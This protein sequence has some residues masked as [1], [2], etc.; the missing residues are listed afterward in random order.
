[1][2]GL[3]A[4][5]LQA[6]LYRRL[7]EDAALGDLVGAAIYD[8]PLER[9]PVAHQNRSTS[10]GVSRTRNAQPWLKPALG[11]RWACSSIRSTAAG[12]TGSGE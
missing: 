2:S 8:A 4:A 5:E 7:A 10:V 6:G 12:S 9:A 11:A 3:F 1:M